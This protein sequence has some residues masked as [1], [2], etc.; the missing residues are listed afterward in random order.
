MDM[1]RIL[2]CLE[3]LFAFAFFNSGSTNRPEM[4]GSVT[5][6]VSCPVVGLNEGSSDSDSSGTSR[7][8]FNS[9]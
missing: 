1:F 2:I 7:L 8:Y 4:D 6:A 3:A 9:C 5:G